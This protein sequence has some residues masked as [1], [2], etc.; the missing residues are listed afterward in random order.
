MIGVGDVVNELECQANVI[1]SELTGDVR[2]V[3]VAVTQVSEL[4]R[5]DGVAPCGLPLGRA[6][7]LRCPVGSKHNLQRL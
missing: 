2:C 6:K 3:D 1:G 7:L 5:S 4:G